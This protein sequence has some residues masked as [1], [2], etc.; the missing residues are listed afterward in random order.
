MER[1]I[2]KN[3]LLNSVTFEALNIRLNRVLYYSFANI[4]NF[5][6]ML[7]LGLHMSLTIKC[8]FIYHEQQINSLLGQ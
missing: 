5:N 4:V 3:E 7:N 8:G 2:K 6:R 1:S